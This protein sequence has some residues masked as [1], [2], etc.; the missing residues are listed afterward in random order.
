[1]PRRIP[2]AQNTQGCIYTVFVICTALIQNVDNANNEDCPFNKFMDGNVCKDCPIGHFGR[3]C[4]DKCPPRN[5]GYLC[6]QEC[7]HNC[8]SCHYIFGCTIIKET[9]ETTSK[10]IEHLTSDLPV[11]HAVNNTTYIKIITS[12][13][14]KRFTLKNKRLAN[15]ITIPSTSNALSLVRQFTV[16]NK[17]M[18]NFTAIPNP[19]SINY[20]LLEKKSSTINN[21]SLIYANVHK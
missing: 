18:T 7:P 21:N 19:T 6:G 11:S 9:K 2:K 13:P 12:S 3:N 17:R 14:I 20:Q 1:M 8:K 16:T 5:F 4:A 10:I 15:T